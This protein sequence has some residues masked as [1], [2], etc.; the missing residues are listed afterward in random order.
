MDI[1][2]LPDPRYIRRFGVLFG[3]AKIVLLKE[4]VEF[5]KKTVLDPTPVP[6]FPIVAIAL[7][8]SNLAS[9]GT[10][11]KTHSRGYLFQI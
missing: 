8:K 2:S 5:L 4:N 6:H 1:K 9:I 10:L 7:N 3:I 11:L